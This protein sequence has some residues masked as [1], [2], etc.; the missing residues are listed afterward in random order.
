MDLRVRLT[1]G[2]ILF[3]KTSQAKLNGFHKSSWCKRLTPS[4][5]RIIVTSL[6][7][8]P[9]VKLFKLRM[10]P[11]V[12]TRRIYKGASGPWLCY[13]H[14]EA[15]CGCFSGQLK[16]LTYHTSNYAR[17]QLH[18]Y[19]MLIEKLIIIFYGQ[20]K[21]FRLC[22]RTISSWSY[23]SPYYDIQEIMDY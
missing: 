20:S 1:I 8:L 9:I 23:P 16:H 3:Y 21:R 4:F 6:S 12:E 11:N 14:R 19:A 10:Q 7:L 22:E 13:A 17:E 18:D 2:S 5:V 15:H